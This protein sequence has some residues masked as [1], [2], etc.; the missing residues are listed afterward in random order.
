VRW[1]HE[2]RAIEQDHATLYGETG[3]HY[4]GSHKDGSCQTVIEFT[5]PQARDNQN[6]RGPESGN[7]HSK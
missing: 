4:E 7:R 3:H 6:T 1:D 5:V 2:P